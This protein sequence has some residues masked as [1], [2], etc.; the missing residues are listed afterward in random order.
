MACLAKAVLLKKL[1]GMESAAEW[2]AQPPEVV[3]GT[4]VGVEALLLSS[5]PAARGAHLALDGSM[6]LV[7]DTLQIS[8]TFFSS[9]MSGSIPVRP[10]HVLCAISARRTPPTSARW[11]LI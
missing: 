10:A 7:L 11:L 9:T 2:L 4:V 3:V 8:Q 5:R 6:K 1:D